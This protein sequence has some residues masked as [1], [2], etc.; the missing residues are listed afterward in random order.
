MN[1]L[2]ESQHAEAINL[3]NKAENLLAKL[4]APT[5]EEVEKAFST[6]T[7]PNGQ[8]I[9]PFTG[10]YSMSAAPGAF[11]SVDTTELYY[12]LTQKITISA[13]SATVTVSMDGKTSTT[14][15]L[16]QSTSFDGSTLTIPGVLTITF[17]RAYNNGVLVTFAGTV[18][19]TAVTG[20]TQFNPIALSTFNGLYTALPSLK[21]VL[22]VHDS[23][24]RIPSVSFDTSVS[25]DFG[26]GLREL[27]LFTFV[28]LMFVLSFKNPDSP[29]DSYILMLGTAGSKGLA[30]FI[31][32]G[33]TGE[34]AFTIP[35][36][37]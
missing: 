11:L 28:P 29:S 19:N 21:Q 25:F 17:K 14:Y 36:G 22:S 15:P 35:G 31:N 6:I 4:K 12:K 3:H 18:N 7:S 5:K 20:S 9:I 27:K 23:S 26:S 34:Y 10:Y 24:K 8:S 2:K 13:A 16:N 33:S 37:Q 1:H 30:C 32:Q